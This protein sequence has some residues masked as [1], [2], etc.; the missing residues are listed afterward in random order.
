[1]RPSPRSAAREG[2]SKSCHLWRTRTSCRRMQGQPAPH[3][4]RALE[5]MTALYALLDSRGP[6]YM[7]ISYGPRS[8]TGSPS[9][10]QHEGHDDQR[11]W[12]LDAHRVVRPLYVLSMGQ[13]DRVYRTGAMMFAAMLSSTLD[14]Y[15]NLHACPPRALGAKASHG[16]DRRG[17]GVQ[18]AAGRRRHSLLP[19]R[20]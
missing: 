15:R 10:C 3:D 9:A 5:Q 18:H 14:A 19:P 1:M 12:P 16:V 8:D 7:D 17:V 4:E 6:L 13:S 20:A 11:R 2:A